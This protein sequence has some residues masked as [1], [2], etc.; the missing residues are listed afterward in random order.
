MVHINSWAHIEI[1][2]VLQMPVIS[3]HTISRIDF[4]VSESYLFYIHVDIFPSNTHSMHSIKHL[5]LPNGTQFPV[6]DHGLYKR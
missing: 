4:F 2:T 1:L 6:T 3:H 5:L